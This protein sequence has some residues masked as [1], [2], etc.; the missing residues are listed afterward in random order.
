MIGVVS[1]AKGL[2]TAKFA[3]MDLVEISPDAKPPVCK[4]MDYSKHRF[5]QQKKNQQARKK[6]KTTETKEIKVRPNIAEGDYQVKLKR[7][8][9]FIGEG[10]KVKITL[11]FR[12]REVTHDELGFAVI[13]KFKD[14]THDIA[15]VEFDPKK[16]RK[17]IFM[18]LAPL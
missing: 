15:K 6:Q 14:D 16:E 4:I 1:L 11:M 5:E 18:V 10:N 3:G 2:E 13:N 12:G 9:K 17:N 7:V 8:K